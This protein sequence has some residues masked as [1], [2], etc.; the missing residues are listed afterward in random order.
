MCSEERVILQK[1]LGCARPCAQEGLCNVATNMRTCD[2]FFR[3]NS[4]LPCDGA[5]FAALEDNREL[6]HEM[7]IYSVFELQ[8]F[9]YEI[10]RN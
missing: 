7:G 3:K 10:D 1:V 9:L 5:L 2:E 8:N 4:I 6:M